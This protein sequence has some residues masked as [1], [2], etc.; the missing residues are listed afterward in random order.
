MFMQWA[1]GPV[2][3]WGAQPLTREKEYRRVGDDNTVWFRPWEKYLDMA[4]KIELLGFQN[5]STKRQR[6]HT[7]ALK[8]VFL[9][10]DESETN[11]LRQSLSTW[12]L[13]QYDYSLS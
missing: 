5:Q 12:E 10:D 3:A 9:I 11:I 2:F 7:F 1:K 6:H 4:N 13:C 8:Q